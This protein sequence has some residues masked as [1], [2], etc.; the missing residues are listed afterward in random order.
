MSIAANKRSGIRAVLANNELTAR[1]G[2]AH[3]DANVLCLGER[4]TGKELA[5]AIVDAFL[6]A[7][8]DAEERHM[9]RVAKLEDSTKDAQG[10]GKPG[11]C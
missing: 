4:F 11:A 10:D 9:R 7:H 6:E 5:K 2:R 1:M 3:N 8:F